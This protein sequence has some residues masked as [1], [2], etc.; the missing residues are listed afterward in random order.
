VLPP[1]FAAIAERWFQD[2]QVAAVVGPIVQKEARNA[3]D[4]WRGRHLFQTDKRTAVQEDATFVTGG[5]MLRAAAASNAGG[6]DA[7]REH[8]EDADL[9]RRLLDRGYK[10]IFDPTLTYWQLGSNSIAEALER[11]WRWN[12]AQGRMTASAYL[13][14]IKYSLTVMAREDMQTADV[15]AALISLISP[16]Y[17]FWRDRRE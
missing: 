14:Q 2:D 11:Y 3:A 9:G 6:Y 17:Q 4:R 5:A 8:G 1:D 7:S 15:G 16:H 12:R 13:K 10:V